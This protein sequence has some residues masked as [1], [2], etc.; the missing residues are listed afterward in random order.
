M[1][2]GSGDAQSIAKQVGQ[3]D[4]MFKR[5]NQQG[6]GQ[7]DGYFVPKDIYNDLTRFI[8]NDD[9]LGARGIK[10]LANAFLRGKALSQYSKTVL[11]PVT[12]IRNFVTAT[13]FAT[14]NGNIPI[15][16]RGGSLRDAGV[17]VFSNIRRMGDEG[18]L[19][20]LEEARRRGILGTN[21]ELREIQ[22]SLRKGVITSQR[23]MANQ[24]GMS[25]ILGESMAKS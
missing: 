7:L 8:A 9:T 18:V 21:T 13:T 25:A 24:D 23:D 6:W 15:F 22:D 20:E 19:R 3:Q 1:Q 4:E 16:G 10:Y 14:A 5:L 11:S 12:Q 2:L 17:A